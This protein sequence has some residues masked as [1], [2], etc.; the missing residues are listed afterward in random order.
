MGHFL[1]NGAHHRGTDRGRN[2]SDCSVRV[3]SLRVVGD[4]HLDWQLCL[5][6]DDVAY[7]APGP[8]R[9]R[10]GED[11]YEAY[12]CSNASHPDG[13]YCMVT[14]GGGGISLCYGP[15]VSDSALC[16]NKD[17]VRPW[18]ETDLCDR[19]SNRP[20]MVQFYAGTTLRDFLRFGELLG[21]QLLFPA[22]LEER[23][24]VGEEDPGDR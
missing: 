22:V 7:F 16:V 10:N 14:V 18:I 9:D 3:W 12:A 8:A 15:A 6:R 21:A 20:I 24:I 23:D 11:W 1:W 17:K 19:W 4:Y 13:D 2:V 5:F